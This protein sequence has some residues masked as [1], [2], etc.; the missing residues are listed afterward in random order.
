MEKYTI[1]G[2]DVEYDTFDL[3]NMEL[4]ASESKKVVE[5]IKNDLSAASGFDKLH[6]YVEIVRDFFDTLIG[7]GTAEKVFGER[8]NIRTIRNGYMDFVRKVVAATEEFQHEYDGAEKL[9]REQRRAAERQ[10][11]R[12]EAAKRAALISGEA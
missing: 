10:K 11:R 6:E 3:T 4:F 5:F 2:V 8:D 9:N 7:D 1:N 12:E